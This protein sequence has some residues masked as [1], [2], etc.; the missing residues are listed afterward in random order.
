MAKKSSRGGG[1]KVFLGFLLGVAGAAG[2][3]YAWLHYGGSTS[4]L[5]GKLPSLPAGLTGEVAKTSPEHAKRTP[6]FGTSEDVFEG[7]A[8]VYKARCANCHGSPKSDA[9]FG[10]QMTPPAGQLWRRGR[11]RVTDANPGDVYAKI[12]KGVPGS[13]MPAYAHTLSDTEIWQVTLLLK[14]AGK[15]LPDPVLNI[16]DAK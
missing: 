8:H 14:S 13:G 16:L 3:G 1:G 12:A 5:H 9:A 4:A 10:K 7:G 15:E 6:P 11:N 2:A